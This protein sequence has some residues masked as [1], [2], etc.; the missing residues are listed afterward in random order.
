MQ[1]E[2]SS[3]APPNKPRKLS[4]NLPKNCSML[5]VQQSVKEILFYNFLVIQYLKDFL[6]SDT[7]SNKTIFEVTYI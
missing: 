7:V 1:S 3:S 6:K 2:N 5:N 4:E